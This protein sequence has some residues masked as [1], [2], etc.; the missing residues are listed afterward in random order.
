MQG[1]ALA[2][3]APTWVVGVQVRHTRTQGRPPWCAE[4]RCTVQGDGWAP[5]GAHPGRTREGPTA[6]TPLVLLELG[7]VRRGPVDY[8]GGGPASLRGLHW[9]RYATGSGV[10]RTLL[11]EGGPPCTRLLEALRRQAIDFLEP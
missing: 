5:R 7:Y 3:P 4:A 9:S 10:P 6:R 1:W 2:S 11:V 8:R